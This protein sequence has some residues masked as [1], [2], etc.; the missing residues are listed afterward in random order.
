MKWQVFCVTNCLVNCHFYLLYLLTVGSISVK[1]DLCYP[2]SITTDNKIKDEKMEGRCG[3]E[4]KGK[5]F[6]FKS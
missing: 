6:M 5:E 4:R 3:E 2:H 1:T